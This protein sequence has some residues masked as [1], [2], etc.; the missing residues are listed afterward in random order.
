MY[1]MPMT[2]VGTIV[3][4]KPNF[5]AA[6][7]VAPVNYNPPMIGIALGKPHH[8]NKGI[9]ENKTFSICIPNK[10]LIEKTDYCG[11]VSGKNE[12]K[13]K[14]FKVFYENNNTIPL[15]EECPVC[16]QLQLDQI[17]DLPSNEF[18][19]GKVIATY[20]D[21]DCLTNNLPDINKINPFTLTMPDNQY[22]TA[23]NSIA[24]AWS[25]GK[26]FLNK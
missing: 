25:V 23:G 16:I 21:E 17:I 1:P 7:W 24:K 19:I 11:L 9:K 14:L 4:N 8:T 26:N 12:D 15:L 18:F 10:S 2:L 20:I 22:W 5:M 6:A 13:S 3:D